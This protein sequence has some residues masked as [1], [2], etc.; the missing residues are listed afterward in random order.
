MFSV[1]VTIMG[2]EEVMFSVDACI[3]LPP[4]TCDRGRAA[5]IKVISS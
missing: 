5:S 4:I 3:A 1:V 2:R